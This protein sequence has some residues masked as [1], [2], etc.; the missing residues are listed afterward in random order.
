MI[1]RHLK[2]TFSILADSCNKYLGINPTLLSANRTLPVANTPLHCRIS[3][4][5]YYNFIISFVVSKQSLTSVE[6]HPLQKRAEPKGQM[7]RK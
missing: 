7:S 5:K 2:V 6:Q 4:P 1:V 3:T